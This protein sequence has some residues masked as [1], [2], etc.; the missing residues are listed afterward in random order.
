MKSITAQQF[1]DYVT[2]DPDWAA[3]LHEP[4]EVKGYVK[5]ENHPIRCLSKLLYFTEPDI[6]AE[7]YNCAH[8][9]VAEGNFSAYAGFDFCGIRLI[10]DLNILGKADNG[11][12][13]SL[14]YCKLLK[15]FTG[16]YPGDVACDNS[17]VEELR[18]VIVHGKATFRKCPI[19]I[20]KGK[21]Y[22]DVIFNGA[23]VKKIDVKNFILVP[24]LES[25]SEKALPNTRRLEF[26]RC[27]NLRVLEGNF[28]NRSISLT[29]SG[30]EELGII[31]GTFCIINVVNSTNL[32][33]CR[34]EH[35]KP[36][37]KARLWIE[38]IK[39]AELEAYAKEVE[40]SR[41][42]LRDN[43]DQLFI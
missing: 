15:V 38:D 41:R 35:M 2:A 18:N 3:T 25:N 34:P 29:S 9:E 37:F 22:D 31:T 11:N 39:M 26:D 17:G 19:E 40:E 43:P 1:T 8:L 14:K 36:N 5:L 33:R 21:F 4:L 12:C 13:L 32:K 20:A 27:K 7:F 30:V 6:S 16:E 42:K 28:P 24:L 23:A 10:R